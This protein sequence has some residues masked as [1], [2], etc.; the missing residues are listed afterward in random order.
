MNS[1]KFQVSDYNFS[2]NIE[3]L[4]EDVYPVSDTVKRENDLLSFFARFNVDVQ[5]LYVHMA[6]PLSKTL[7]SEFLNGKKNFFPGMEFEK[8]ESEFEK[9]NLSKAAEKM[10]FEGVIDERLREKIEFLSDIRN[11]L[12]HKTIVKTRD[13]SSI[14]DIPNHEKFDQDMPKETEK[15]LELGVETISKL[16]EI[17]DKRIKR[18][19]EENDF[20][21]WKIEERE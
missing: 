1:E 18:R 5:C 19:V 12:A 6:F 14:G 9:I 20:T 17:R 16:Q 15:V 10:K 21:Y 4:K 13:S 3:Q 2:E 7:N 11:E 8:F